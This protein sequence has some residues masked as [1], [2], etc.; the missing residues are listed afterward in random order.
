M[1]SIGKTV[2][3]LKKFKQKPANH[4]FGQEK[5]LRYSHASLSN[6]DASG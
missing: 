2:E 1:S 5:Q 6:G 4:F 3:R